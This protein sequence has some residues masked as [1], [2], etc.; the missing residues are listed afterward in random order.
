MRVGMTVLMI[1]VA[2][3][4]C[5]SLEAGV[6]CGIGALCVLVMYSL[7]FFSW[8]IVGSVMFWGKINP[9]GICYGPVQAYLYAILIITYV[10]IG[11][12]FLFKM[13]KKDDFQT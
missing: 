2:I 3:T 12:N 9:K 6:A 7:F 4:I 5:K 10:S 11:C 8:T 13:C 1:I